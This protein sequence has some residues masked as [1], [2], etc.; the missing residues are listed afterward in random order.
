MKTFTVTQVLQ[1]AVQIEQNGIEFY[2]DYAKKAK[3]EDVELVF[4]RLAQDE[5]EHKQTYQNMLGKMNKL[6]KS[7][8]FF[9]EY[10]D[11]Y[12]KYAK[13]TIFKRT[14]LRKE[15][16]KLKTIREALDFGIKRELE[17]ITFYHEMSEVVPEKQYKMVKRIINEERKHVMTLLKLK[18]K[19]R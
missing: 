15:F 18:A 8:R 19:F 16:N 4:K 11:A 6:K 3:G 14:I 13:G 2:R 17:S 5:E 12:R 10:F 1:I 7:G 9:G